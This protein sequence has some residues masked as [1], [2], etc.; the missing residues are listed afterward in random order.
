MPP[1]FPSGYYNCRT[2]G[3]AFKELCC[4]RLPVCVR[5]SASPALRLTLLSSLCLPALLHASCLCWGSEVRNTAV[6]NL[7]TYPKQTPVTTMPSTFRSNGNNQCKCRRWRWWA[8]PSGSCPLLEGAL[9]R[10]PVQGAVCEPPRQSWGEV[11]VAGGFSQQCPC[12]VADPLDAAPIAVLAHRHLT[13]QR[14]LH[15]TTHHTPGS[16]W[17]STR[18]SDEPPW[19]RDQGDPRVP[20]REWESND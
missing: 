3:K 8:L 13:S 18:P 20:R 14:R 1:S 4:A 12:L 19:W 7:Y 5:T 6:R 10:G 2:R 15:T 9:G 17:I 11:W 16:A